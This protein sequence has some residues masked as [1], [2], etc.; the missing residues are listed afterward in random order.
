M[1]SFPLQGRK[2]VFVFA[3]PRGGSNLFSALMHNHDK[4]VSVYHGSAVRIMG[5]WINQEFEPG[6]MGCCESKDDLIYSGSTPRKDYDSSSHIVYDKI[7]HSS[8]YGTALLETA[9]QH[10]DHDRFYGIVL[11]RHPISVLASMNAFGR[12]YGRRG[13]LISKESVGN[14][15]EKYFLWQLSL[16]R[17]PDVYGVELG[18]FLGNIKSQYAELCQHLGLDFRDE[19]TSF[20]QTFQRVGPESECAYE[21]RECDAYWGR[22]LNRRNIESKPQPMYYDPK[23]QQP[24]L[25]RGGF[26]PLHELDLE[27]ACNFD[28]KLSAKE[29]AIIRQVFSKAM[30]SDDVNYLFSNHLLELDRI[31]QIEMKDFSRYLKRVSLLPRA[32]KKIRQYVGR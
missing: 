18:S 15:L 11:V 12:R 24:C 32:Y 25:G 10:I 1:D 30:G 6:T 9:L 7:H 17:N 21:I 8:R 14:F 27:R 23:L 16:L 29:S 31:K 26:N 5:K 19:Y 22:F 3:V 2:G 4:V 20:P 28:S 13:W